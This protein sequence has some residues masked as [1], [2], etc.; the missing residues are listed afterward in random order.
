MIN[1]VS[2]TTVPFKAVVQGEIQL[3]ALS[4]SIDQFLKEGK[5]FPLDDKINS[6]FRQ[7]KNGT[8]FRLDYL[9]GKE[10]QEKG[11][12]EHSMYTDFGGVV[13]FITTVGNELNLFIN[14]IKET[15]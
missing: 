13:D 2:E 1:K 4:E 8:E 10:S 15:K 12:K 3:K 14:K 7:T 11:R 9:P 5:A 6:N